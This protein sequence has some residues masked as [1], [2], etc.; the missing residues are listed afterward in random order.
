MANDGAAPM[1]EAEWQAC[2]EPR[3]LLSAY[4]TTVN[5]RAKP[6]ARKVRLFG[7]ACC[8]RIWPL[9]KHPAWRQA[10]EVAERFA[11]GH[12]TARELRT[13]RVGLPDP[14]PVSPDR[15]R[16]AYFSVS[17]VTFSN[18]TYTFRTG[19]W[20]GTDYYVRRAATDVA[21]EGF[22]QE[23]GTPTTWERI[24]NSKRGCRGSRR[25]KPRQTPASC[26]TYSATPSARSPSTRLG[27][28]GMAERS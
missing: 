14:G 21:R 23:S 3:D 25:P 28:V 6:V 2:P 12:A 15:V 17:R 4:G 7:C 22:V 19:H 18:P 1:T 20:N 8:R 16:F 10:V 27:G 24:R 26:E 5:L 11:D 9:L 13:T